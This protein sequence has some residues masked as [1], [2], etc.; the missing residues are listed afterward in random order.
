MTTFVGVHYTDG[1]CSGKYSIVSYS[2]TAPQTTTCGKKTYYL[3]YGQNN[4]ATASVQQPA[5]FQPL[6]TTE[7]MTGWNDLRKVVNKTLPGELHRADIYLR[8]AL[9][10]LR[11]V[12]VQ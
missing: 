12:K 9:R 10:E 6:H 2:S 1:P 11:R 7:A 3:T 8:R 4:T 5:G